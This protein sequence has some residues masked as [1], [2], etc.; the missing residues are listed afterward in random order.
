LPAAAALPIPQADNNATFNLSGSTTVTSFANVYPG[1]N[2]ILLFGSGPTI[3]GGNN[4]ILEG[5][6]TSR[7]AQSII[8]SDSFSCFG[9]GSSVLCKETAFNP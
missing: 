8:S 2:F 9:L 1:E 3:A 6:V 4:I 5:G 7:T